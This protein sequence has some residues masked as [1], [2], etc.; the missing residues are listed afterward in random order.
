MSPKYLPKH[1]TIVFTE[2]LYIAR[3]AVLR[4]RWCLKER[5]VINPTIVYVHRS[6][7]RIILSPPECVAHS[8]AISLYHLLP[9]HSCRLPPPPTLPPHHSPSLAA[10]CGCSGG[11]GPDK[12]EKGYTAVLS[13]LLPAPSPPPRLMNNG[14]AKYIYLLTAT[15]PWLSPKRPRH[16]AEVSEHPSSPRHPARDSLCPLLKSDAS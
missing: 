10:G 14:G 6:N 16:R 13:L 9:H 11:T 4:L 8:I 1:F 12:A 7:T 2:T 3:T 5:V 15:A